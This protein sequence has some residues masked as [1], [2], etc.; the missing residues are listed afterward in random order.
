V[1]R[2]GIVQHDRAP[3]RGYWPERGPHSRRT[4]Q[5]RTVIRGG[6]EPRRR[7]PDNA[8]VIVIESRLIGRGGVMG[9]EMAV[10][11]SARMVLVAF[12]HVL[13]SE[14]GAS[15]HDGRAYN[16]RYRSNSPEHERHYGLADSDGQRI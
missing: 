9:S 5:S 15:S 10:D 12:V 13:R 7:E 11:D 14:R 8:V 2:S 1:R 4:K 16:D 6:L 3:L